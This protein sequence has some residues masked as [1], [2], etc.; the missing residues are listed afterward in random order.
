[1]GE[2]IEDGKSYLIENLDEMIRATLGQVIG[3]NSKRRGSVRVYQLG[4]NEH[5]I[6]KIF[7]LILHTKL[8]YPLYPP[9]IQVELTLI[10]FTVTEDGL[11]DQILALIVK[12]ERPKLAAR[13]ERVIPKQNKC[14]IKLRELE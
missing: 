1:M 2:W 8:S 10:N 4:A 7:K 14:K 12:M 5:E 13:K 6:N 9:Y 11:K 3:R